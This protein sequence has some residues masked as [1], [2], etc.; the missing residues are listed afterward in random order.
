MKVTKAE[1]GVRGGQEPSSYD[2][3]IFLYYD[4]PITRVGHM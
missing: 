2:D 3:N 1:K 4:Y